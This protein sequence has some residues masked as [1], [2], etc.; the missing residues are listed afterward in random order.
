MNIS[1]DSDADVLYLSFETTRGEPSSYVEN[2]QGDILRLC[3]KSKQI[4]GV[5]IPFLT[6]RARTEVLKIP[7]IGVVPFNQRTEA[8]LMPE[9]P[10]KE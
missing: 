3:L 10:R 6:R 4:R 5:T 2:G 7:E 8:L 1:Y 9:E